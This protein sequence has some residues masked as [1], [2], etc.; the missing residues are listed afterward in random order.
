MEPIQ[1]TPEFDVGVFN[2]INLMEENTS[3]LYLPDVAISVNGNVLKPDDGVFT[4]GPG[5]IKIKYNEQVYTI[6]ILGLEPEFCP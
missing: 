1:L 4:I 3:Q 2:C 6:I 5:L